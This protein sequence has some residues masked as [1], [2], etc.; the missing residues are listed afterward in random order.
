MNPDYYRFFYQKSSPN[1]SHG[2]LGHSL[3]AI[4]LPPMKCT[5]PSENKGK[6]IFTAQCG[7]VFAKFYI[8]SAPP[9]TFFK[10][11]LQKVIDQKKQRTSS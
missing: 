6:V 11:A 9:S 1:Q 4:F 8:S 3:K 10:K 7:D 2:L 5:P